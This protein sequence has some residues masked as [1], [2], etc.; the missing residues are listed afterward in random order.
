MR[1]K[2]GLGNQMFQYALGR[3][4]SLKNKTELV[5][6]TEAYEDKTERPFTHNMP[7]RSYDLDVFNTVGRIAKTSEIPWLYRMYGKGNL[8]LI[9]DAVRRRIFR[10]KAQEIYFEKFNP[11]LLTLGPSA[12]IDGFFQTPKYMI[13]YEDIIRKD[14]TLTHAPAQNI[15]NCAEEISN[16]NSLCIHVRRGDYVGNAYHEV[17]NMEYYKKGIEIVSQKTNPETIYVFSDD[18][19]WC[20]EHMKFD[21]PTVFVDDTYA[22]I[23]G[24]GH[25]YLMSNCKNFIIANSSFSWWAAWLSNNP[26]K[27]VICPKQWF[28]DVSIDTSDLIPKSWIRI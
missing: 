17:V 11:A 6:N 15:K 23:K 12:Y 3:V 25:M 4:L 18:I 20:K 27:I 13:G 22:G 24:E 19:S 26:D 2:G 1:L 7:A 9:V 10:H 5:F 21:L 14:F 8:M 28:G 16:T